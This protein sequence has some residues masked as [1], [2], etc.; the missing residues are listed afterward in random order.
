[1]PSEQAFSRGQRDGYRSLHFG[2]GRDILGWHCFLEKEQAVG[3]ERAN[4]LERRVGVPPAMYVDGDLVIWP[5]RRTHRL[6]L[7]GGAAQVFLRDLSS[8]ARP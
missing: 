6:D 5:A 3:L 4:D 2:H 1:M 8:E 7:C